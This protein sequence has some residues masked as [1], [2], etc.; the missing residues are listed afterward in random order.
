MTIQMGSSLRPK[1][2]CGLIRE[3]GS[4]NRF[5]ELNEDPVKAASEDEGEAAFW[6]VLPGNRLRKNK[7][8]NGATINFSLSHSSTSSLGRYP[9][10]SFS[11][12]KA[13]W[14][15]VSLQNGAIVT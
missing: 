11:D 2:K 13:S 6:K 15:W 8:R 9:V 10:S 14:E 1:E 4:A 12:I 3:E 7:L 5:D